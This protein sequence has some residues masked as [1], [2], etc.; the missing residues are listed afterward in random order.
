MAPVNGYRPPPRA[1]TAPWPGQPN[2][3]PGWLAEATEVRRRDDMVKAELRERHRQRRKE[4][5][6]WSPAHEISQHR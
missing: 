3:Q 4:R 1:D 2:R 5:E 6:A